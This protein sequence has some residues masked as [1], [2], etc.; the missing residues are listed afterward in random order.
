MFRKRPEF[1]LYCDDLTFANM[2]QPQAEPFYFTSDGIVQCTEE[3][4]GKVEK[5]LNVLSRRTEN[6]DI[7]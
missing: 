2:C 4:M 5:R 6:I 1:K 3:R 7:D